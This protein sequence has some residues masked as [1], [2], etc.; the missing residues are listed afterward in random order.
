MQVL[1]E[2]VN[3]EEQICKFTNYFDQKKA[4][5]YTLVIVTMV[6][7]EIQNS[8]RNISFID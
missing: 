2:Q 8:K 6:I 3:R 7:Q 4:I 5:T 1:C